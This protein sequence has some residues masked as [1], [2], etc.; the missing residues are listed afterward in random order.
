MVVVSTPKSSPSSIDVG[1][2]A[3]GS[4]ASDPMAMDTVTPRR[5]P[6]ML[7]TTPSTP[8]SSRYCI[9]MSLMV[10]PKAFRTPI[11][12]ILSFT[13]SIMTLAMPM[14]PTTKDMAPMPARAYLIM[15]RML[16]SEESIS[17]AVVAS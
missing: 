14:P 13:V 1:V 4:P 12:L 15:E 7:L 5:I 3:D 11:S 8:A 6:M 17:R 10:A 9:L 2:M 16:I